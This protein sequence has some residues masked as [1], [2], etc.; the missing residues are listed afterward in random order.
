MVLGQNSHIAWGF[1]S[2]ET[3]VQDLFLEKLVGP[4]GTSY[5]TPGGSRRFE[6]RTKIIRVRGK[7]DIKLTVRNTR[8]GPVISDLSP[9]IKSLAS[10][11]H[12]LAL[13]TPAL[14]EDD[15]SVLASYKLN[16]ATS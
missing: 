6:V 8:H 7:P 16:H 4:E 5:Q 15:E 14:R 9:G 10:Q 3:D 11:G 12:V 1:T 2:A 13:A